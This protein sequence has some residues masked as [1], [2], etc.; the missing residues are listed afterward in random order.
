[1]TGQMTLFPTAKK[2]EE[3]VEEKP[4]DV[5]ITTKKKA[6]NEVDAVELEIAEKDKYGWTQLPSNEEK[7]NIGMDYTH[8]QLFSQSDLTGIKYRVSFSE[9]H[10]NPHNM[11]GSGGGDCSFNPNLDEIQ[12][13][14]ANIMERK[15]RQLQEPYR[16]FTDAEQKISYE[17]HLAYYYFRLVPAKNYFVVVADELVAMFQKAGFDFETWYKEYRTLPENKATEQ[18]WQNA[19]DCLQWLERGDKVGNKLDALEPILKLK[20][21]DELKE[22]KKE[23]KALFEKALLELKDINDTLEKL[24]ER[25][26]YGHD[27]KRYQDLLMKCWW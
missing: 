21:I 2:V 12:E 20:N 3:K 26:E 6:D 22:T 11:L 25:D 5:V 15:K 7:K 9:S 10:E 4:E 16:E 18:D 8:I 27:I 14:F 24:G 17:H 13:V 1:M 23:V 19:L